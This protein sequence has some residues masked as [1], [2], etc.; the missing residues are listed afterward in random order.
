MVY[1]GSVN[2]TKETISLNDR[3]CYQFC[4]CSCYS[5]QK[6]ALCIHVVSYSN[7]HKHDWYGARFRQPDKFEI[8]TKKGAPVKRLAS[9]RFKLASKALNYD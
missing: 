8:K 7:I 3:D 4:N 1:T 5:F 6:W 9:G 2:G